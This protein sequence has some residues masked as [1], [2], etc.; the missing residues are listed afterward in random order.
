MQS[1]RLS[2]T[3]SNF[4]RISTIVHI[5]LEDHP[6]S[7]VSTLVPALNISFPSVQR[8]RIQNLGERG[9][10]LTAN[11]ENETS[12]GFEAQLVAISP[13]T[14]VLFKTWSSMV[15][16]LL[17]ALHCPQAENRES[18]LSLLQ[19]L[20]DGSPATRVPSRPFPVVGSIGV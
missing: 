20:D 10:S 19:T 7:Q 9:R 16:E 1:C 5:S 11:L 2:K 4:R 17:N 3:A 18:Q 15:E 14:A 13:G 8:F 12:I 6:P